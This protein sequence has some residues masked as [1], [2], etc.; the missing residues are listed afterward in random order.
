MDDDVDIGGGSVGGNSSSISSSQQNLLAPN[1]ASGMH[2]IGRR[3]SFFQ[4]LMPFSTINTAAQLFQNNGNRQQNSFDSSGGSIEYDQ[5]DDDHQEQHHIINKNYHHFGNR[6]SFKDIVSG[7]HNNHYYY[8][9]QQMHSNNMMKM[10][11]MGEI[12]L[13]FIM[14]KGF[15]EIEVIAARDLPDS[16]SGQGNPPGKRRRRVFWFCFQ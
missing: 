7:G 15:L 8:N 3:R 2:Q 4:R 10:F 13:G 5:N 16:V 12:K 14:T 11:V 1:W 6:S 9:N